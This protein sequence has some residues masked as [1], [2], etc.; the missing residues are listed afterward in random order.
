MWGVLEADHLCHFQLDIAVDKVIVEYAP[1]FEELTVLVQKCNRFAQ[2]AA[3]RRYLLQLSR[4]KI[5]QVLVD[6][7]SGIELVL[8]SIEPCHQHG[9]KSQIRVSEGVGK[10]HFDAAPLGRGSERDA[11]GS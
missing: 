6:G 7:S 2:R 8:D 1:C 4:R 3:N 5:V 9:G 11:A 10:P